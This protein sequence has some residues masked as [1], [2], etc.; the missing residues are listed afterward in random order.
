MLFQG[1]RRISDFKIRRNGSQSVVFHH[2]SVCWRPK[3]VRFR[4]VSGFKSVVKN[5]CMW[6]SKETSLL[7]F[8]GGPIHGFEGVVKYF[9]FTSLLGLR[10]VNGFSSVAK[11]IFWVKH[12]FGVAT[13]ID[14]PWIIRRMALNSIPGRATGV[15]KS[16]SKSPQIAQAS[17]RHLQGR[18]DTST[19]HE[20]LRKCPK[21]CVHV[22]FQSDVFTPILGVG[23]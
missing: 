11:T 6:T 12:R 18:H 10:C 23:L 17:Q 9:Y 20:W 19:V 5:V 13:L 4:F 7:R 3:R 8:W 16:S 1:D 21:K 15:T 2:I 22:D 14:N